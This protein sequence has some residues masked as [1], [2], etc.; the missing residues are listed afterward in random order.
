M[1]YKMLLRVFYCYRSY[2]VLQNANKSNR[3]LLLISLVWSSVVITKYVHVLLNSVVLF[4]YKPK[5]P[6]CIF[7]AVGSL[8]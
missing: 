7:F 5:H 8:E 3:V 6:V 4:P 1:H 2:L